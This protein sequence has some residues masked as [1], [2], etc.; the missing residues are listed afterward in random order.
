MVCPSFLFGLMEDQLVEEFHDYWI[1]LVKKGVVK[2]IF[3]FER[4]FSEFKREQGML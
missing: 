1:G 2:N 3:D 4:V